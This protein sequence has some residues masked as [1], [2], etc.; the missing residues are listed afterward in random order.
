M[1]VSGIDRGSQGRIQDFK[2]GGAHLQF[3]LGGISCEKSRFYAQKNPIFSNFKG[4]ARRVH[5]PPWFR[6]KTSSNFQL[7]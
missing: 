2:L 5:P 7:M 1:F 4:G 6:H 3:F